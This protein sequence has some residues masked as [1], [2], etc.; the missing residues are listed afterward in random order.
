MAE[1]RVQFNNIVQNQLP[2][3]IREEFPLI[4]EFLK[5][6]YIGQEYQGAPIDLIQNI[7]KYIKLDETTNLNYSAVLVSDI[8]FE[9]TTITIDLGSTPTGTIG[10]PDKYGLL[11]I[12]NEIITYS[13][14]TSSTF[15]GCIRGFVGI[16]SYREESNPENLVFENTE[17]DE[18]KQGAVIENL[19]CLFLK[20][21]LKKTKHQLL[22][23]LD[24]REL[25]SDLNQNLFIKQS[26]DFY[27]SRGTDRS[28][29]ILFKALYNE[30][31]KVI[32][33]RDFV[34]TPS[35]SD[36]RVT[37]DLVVEPVE[38]DPMN[39]IQAT[40]FQEE[41]QYASNINKAYAPV[42]N[43]EKIDV[44]VGKSFYRISLDAGY[45][46]DL[47]VD[48]AIYGAFSVH[49][50]TRV[51]GQVS[52]GSSFFSVD[53]TVGFG[54]IG[55]LSV[56]Y[57]DLTVGIVSYTSKSLTE[58]YGCTNIEKT[59]LDAT[60]VGI[61]TFAYGRSFLDQN[62]I[63]TVRINSVLNKFNYS[64]NNNLYSVGDIAKIKTLGR[65]LTD[66]KFKNW[67]YNVAST[68]TVKNITLVDS[69]DF[70]YSL[71]LNNEHYFRIGDK[72]TLSNSNGISVDSTVVTIVSDKTISVKGQGQLA[73]NLKY[74]VHRKLLKGSSNTL[75]AA[76]LYATN[77]QSTY[78][79][80]KDLYVASSSIPS[81]GG[82][83]LNATDRSFVFSGTFLGENLQIST[84]DHGFFTGDAVYY[85][86]QKI[87]ESFI[88]AV[89]IVTTRVAIGSSL[90][91]NFP[92]GLYYIKRVSDNT[93]K[94]ARSKNDILNSK[95]VSVESQTTV[96]DNKIQPYQFNG[97]TLQTQ[98][99]IRK[100]VT[101]SYT[102]SLTKTEPG[103]TGIFINGVEILNYKSNDTIYYGRIDDVEVISSGFDYDLIDPPLLSV[104]DSV[105]TGATGYVAL[106]GS[107]DRIRVIDP[108]FDYIDTPTV[109]I[110]GGNGTGAKASVNMKLIDHSVSFFA[111]ASSERGGLG[112]TL[113]TSG[114]GTY[115]K[116]RNGGRVVSVAR[117]Q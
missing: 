12:D 53:S 14:K 75:P 76:S 35:N 113:S 102:G 104:Q 6:Y 109:F 71:E 115:H 107:L 27:L 96:T 5:Q 11:K 21:F 32:K 114:C 87:I 77:V 86:P 100:V 89:G 41:Y 10:F 19:S 30:D 85:E 26:K 33:P 117:H 63:I 46:R 110:S 55:E 58:F 111:E 4:S 8:S 24:D 42:T 74:T 79:D 66:F 31:V 91:P 84:N 22:P 7:D 94:F 97:R 3:Y 60:D 65:S 56:T 16:T 13:D 101:P 44:G 1:N 45:N 92:E 93:V 34:F 40:L 47:N 116:F 20:E 80:D 15:T 95:F 57:S 103:F 23:L 68:Y 36:F 82:S 37:N 38:G 112:S 88:D 28:F 78:I 99:L 61:N 67:F 52:S 106:S 105:G 51:I 54:T 49:P 108:G 9:D 29:E 17:V 72:I 2:S 48:G 90:G 59:I 69:S 25:T 73:S 64:P 98:K 43:V 70:S 50:K 83:P 18:H 62:E 39:L 81:Y